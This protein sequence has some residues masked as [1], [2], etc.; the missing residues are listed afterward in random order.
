MNIRYQGYYSLIGSDTNIR[1]GTGYLERML[2]RLQSQ[3][4]LA[5]A[6]YNAGPSRVTSWLPEHQQM[7]AIRWIETI[8]FTETREYV[9][10]VLAYMAI[11]EH[12]MQQDIT[13]LSQRMPP[14]PARN[15]RTAD[16]AEHPDQAAQALQSP[17]P[18]PS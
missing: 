17:L 14:V 9:S 15:Q 18:D 12:R 8:P 16:N 1:L 6:A 11:Y 4:V 13:P 5:T 7:E 2:N 3:H 10:N